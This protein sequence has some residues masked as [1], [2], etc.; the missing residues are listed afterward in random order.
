MF[1]GT[2]RHRLVFDQAG[3]RRGDP[4]HPDVH[5][6]EAQAH[7]DQ[8]LRDAAQARLAARARTVRRHRRHRRDPEVTT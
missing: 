2:D 4:M 3:T 1:L 7:I 6:M 8:R 5:T